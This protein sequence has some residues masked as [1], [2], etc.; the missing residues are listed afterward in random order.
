MRT[1]RIKAS[2]DEYRNTHY[3]TTFYIESEK[4][5]IGE[6]FNPI[7]G[8]KITEVFPVYADL[9]LTNTYSPDCENFFELWGQRFSPTRKTKAALNTNMSQSPSIPSKKMMRR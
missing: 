1:I 9:H 6:D 7:Y 4:P 2:M 3:Y 5:E 8:T